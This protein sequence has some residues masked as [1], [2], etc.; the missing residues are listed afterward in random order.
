GNAG[1][2]VLI[3]GTG[4]SA[5]GV[6]QKNPGKRFVVIDKKLPTSEFPAGQW[7]SYD[8]YCQGGSIRCLVNGTLQNEGTNADP[9]GGWIALQSE[10]SPIE[11]RNVSLEPVD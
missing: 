11:F 4:L 6:S 5:N 8:I 1:D 10:G 7:N 3:N 9:A 2:F